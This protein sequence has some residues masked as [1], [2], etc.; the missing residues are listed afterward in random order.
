M[1]ETHGRYPITKFA[2]GC[3]ILKHHVVKLIV[4]YGIPSAIIG[5]LIGVCSELSRI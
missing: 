3:Y 5:L 1:A 4:L 2:L